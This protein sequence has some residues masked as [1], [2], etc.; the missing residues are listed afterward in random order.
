VCSGGDALSWLVG[1]DGLARVEMR[2][3]S[4]VDTAD[5]GDKYVEVVVGM[6]DGTGAREEW[7]VA[8]G[9]GFI[10]IYSKLNENIIN[11][12]LSLSLYQYTIKIE[13]SFHYM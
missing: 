1:G 12:I 9:V 10:N 6:G 3:H 5:S 13:V 2:Q 11:D 7:D 4:L 8:M